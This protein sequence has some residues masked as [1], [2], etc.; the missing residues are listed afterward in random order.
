MP[1]QFRQQV[2]KL[3]EK[4]D[5]TAPHYVRCIKPNV[6]L[7]PD[8][9]D[10]AMV[11]H[12]LRCGGVLQAVSVTRD[13]FTLHYT[14]ADFLERYNV[15]MS[16]SEDG[17]GVPTPSKSTEVGSR[18]K[19]CRVLVDALLNKI[20]TSA[21]EKDGTTASTTI[22]QLPSKNDNIIDTLIQFGKSKVLLKHHAFETLE[23]MLTAVQNKSATK[24][25]A[26]FRRYL[27]RVAFISVRE[28]FLQEFVFE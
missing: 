25:N 16:A 10:A 2:K 15:L 5:S 19:D 28:S 9:F 20:S 17:T 3:R 13:G 7:A 8:H 11:A 27:C 6:L 23:L 26:I 12:Q 14:H 4:I 22:A 24:L 21:D 18:A 1:L